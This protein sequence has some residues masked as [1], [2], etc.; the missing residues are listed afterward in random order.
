MGFTSGIAAACECLLERWKTGYFNVSALSYECG[1]G[2][3]AETLYL[4]SRAV[5]AVGERHRLAGAVTSVTSV[6]G[7]IG[8]G[9]CT[10][11][12]TGAA[13]GLDEQFRPL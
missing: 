2:W 1:E 11:T 5:R 9:T 3:Y 12:C 4:R 10:C 8:I 7:G 6:T 13:I